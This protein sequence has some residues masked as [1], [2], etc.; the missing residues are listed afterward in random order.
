MT[1]KLLTIWKYVQATTNRREVN[2][3]FSFAKDTIM[4]W[5]IEL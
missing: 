2:S 4:S 3:D 1:S 5:L